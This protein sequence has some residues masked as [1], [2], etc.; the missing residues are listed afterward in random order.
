MRAE[1][2]I[3]YSYIWGILFVIWGLLFVGLGLF[4]SLMSNGEPAGKE[5]TEMVQ[6]AKSANQERQ[7]NH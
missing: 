5:K 3:G 6:E 7:N 4:T 2:N 1:R